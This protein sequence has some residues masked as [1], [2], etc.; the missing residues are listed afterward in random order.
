MTKS[1]TFPMPDAAARFAAAD[2]GLA[3]PL[4]AAPVVVA[5]VDLSVRPDKPQYT[6]HQAP[7]V[8]T[9]TNRNPQ[10]SKFASSNAGF[11]GLPPRD[12]PSD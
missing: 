5:G 8:T 7:I 11:T 4:S 1:M 3:R 10:G 6:R 9:T 2:I 12:E